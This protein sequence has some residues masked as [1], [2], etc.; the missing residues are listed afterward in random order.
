MRH[1][2]CVCDYIVEVGDK[3]VVME[4]TKTKWD[5]TLPVDRCRRRRMMA[6]DR[7]SA[8]PVFSGKAHRCAIRVYPIGQYLES[9]SAQ[10]LVC[11]GVKSL[12]SFIDHV[13]LLGWSFAY[14]YTR[15]TRWLSTYHTRRWSLTDMSTD[16]VLESS[17]PNVKTN[18]WYLR[19]CASFHLD[20]LKRYY[21]ELKCTL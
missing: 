12:E 4:T 1:Y 6:Q 21:V 8:G 5:E 7:R 15:W 20:G 3:T 9:H 18:L 14:T 10:V 16:S 13:V 17:T 2:I 11:E 19:V